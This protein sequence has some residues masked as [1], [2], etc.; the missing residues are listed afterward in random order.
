MI[1][2]PGIP[3][4]ARFVSGLAGLLLAGAAHADFNLRMQTDL[5]AID[6]LMLDTVA[7]NTVANF[8]N[9]VNDGDYTN[10]VIHRRALYSDPAGTIYPLGTP[11][12]LQGGG[13]TYDT[14]VSGFI[15]EGGAV[16]IP[17][18]PPV[19]DEFG[20]SNLRGTVAMA[21]NS[22]NPLNSATSEWFVNLSDN[23]LSLDDPANPFTVF[24]RVVGDSMDV[25]DAISALPVCQ[26]FAPF[27]FLCGK[28]PEVPVANTSSVFDDSTLVQI[29]YIGIDTDADGLPDG[30]ED[31]V[32]NGGDG[33]SDSIADSTQQHVASYV[34]EDGG[35]IVLETQPGRPPES[36][37]VMGQ[38]FGLAYPPESG[39]TLETL[40]G[41]GLRFE[42]GYASFS[43]AG[44]AGGSWTV[45]LTLPSGAAPDTY[46]NYGPTVS[47]TTPHWYEF[48]FD[49]TTGAQFSGNVVTLTYV[50]GARGDS[51]LD[52]GNG[53]IKAAPGG[54][55]RV[56]GDTDG[57]PDSEEDGGPNGGDGNNDGLPDSTQD[58]VA[59][60]MD[61]NGVYLTVAALPATIALDSVTTE[62]GDTIFR[63]N[64][65]PDMAGLNFLHGLVSF[66]LTNVAPGGAATVDLILP[67]TESPVR[68][69]KFGPTPGN[70][71]DEFYSFTFDQASGTGAQISGNVIT[72]N[73]VDGQR[74]DADLTADGIITDPGA[75]AVASAVETASSGGGCTLYRNSD[76]TPARAGAWWLLLGFLAV[77]KLRQRRPC[78]VIAGGP[79]RPRS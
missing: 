21:K 73:Y 58:N 70:A 31:Q 74:G 76:V 45:T 23:D 27:S 56:P 2:F 69:Y 12:V 24:A 43:N 39:S 52:A 75:P 46:F 10:T 51:D 57:I 5:G 9:Y 67:A 7:P 18:D 54:A 8:M 4:R 19:D 59:S 34:D 65:T 77:M 60:F 29:K 71:T 28:F 6:L 61:F 32:S 63:D 79:A 44:S 53:I 3:S 48:N 35:T 42:H 26:D 11:F 41:I 16:H 55:T 25:V 64:L 1:D 22:A 66:N 20:L 49:G 36:V 50:D 33:N 17:V 40:T 62:R 37:S 68:Y 72:L 47:D 13:Y 38:T 78:K 30:M 15:S 14:S